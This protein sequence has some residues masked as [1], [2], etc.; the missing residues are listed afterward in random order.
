MIIRDAMEDDF[1]AIAAIYND[2]LLTSTAIYADDPATV[3]ERIAWWKARTRQNYPTLVACDG[4]SVIGF[5]SFGDFRAW[6]GYRFT[7][8]HTVHVDA[9]WRGKG[10]G[11][12]LLRALIPR[13]AALG[14]HMMIG[15]IDAQNVASLRL[16]ERLGFERVAHFKEVGFKF[17]RFLDLVFVQLPIGGGYVTPPAARTKTAPS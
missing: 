1:Q 8:E 11:S 17:G 13:A 16:H 10:A 3:D 5:S 15:G 9:A 6:P 7:V 2:V 12:A 14:K 4:G